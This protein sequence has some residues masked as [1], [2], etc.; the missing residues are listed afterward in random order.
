MR[1][2]NLL[3][4]SDLVKNAITYSRTTK[5]LQNT[6]WGKNQ[7]AHAKLVAWAFIRKGGI[8]IFPFRNWQY[9]CSSDLIR[10]IRLYDQFGSEN[11]PPCA[12]ASLR[13][14]GDAPSKLPKGQMR[15]LQYPPRVT[16]PRHFLYPASVW[17]TRQL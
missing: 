17:L 7:K 10:A 4:H 12:P 15:R 16:H 14:K 11:R 9:K 3:N 5:Q 1:C 13:P 2:F 6:E 8:N